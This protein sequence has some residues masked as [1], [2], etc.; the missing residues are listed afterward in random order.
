MSIASKVPGVEEVVAVTRCRSWAAARQ[1]Q[2][3]LAH[4][5]HAMTGNDRGIAFHTGRGAEVVGTVPDWRPDDVYNNG[6]N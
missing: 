6:V 4:L 2:P 5:E 3:G 1:R